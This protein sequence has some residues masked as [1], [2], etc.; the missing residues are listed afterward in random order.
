MSE[1]LDRRNQAHFQYRA[2]VNYR[3]ERDIRPQ[4]PSQLSRKLFPAGT[5]RPKGKHGFTC[6]VRTAVQTDVKLLRFPIPASHSP[7]GAANR[8]LRCRSDRTH[9]SV[10]AVYGTSHVNPLSISET[11]PDRGEITCAVRPYA[12]GLRMRV[13]AEGAPI[14]SCPHIQKPTLQSDEVEDAA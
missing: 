13:G 6:R 5:Y 9:G 1:A 2:V 7:T 11:P 12:R 4:W 10:Q 3:K 8:T 14:G